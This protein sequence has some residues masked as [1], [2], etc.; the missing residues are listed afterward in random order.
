MTNAISQNLTLSSRETAYLIKLSWLMESK[1]RTATENFL[2]ELLGLVFSGLK[3]T[4]W[5]AISLRK[6][7]YN[8]LK[9]GRIFE[10]KGSSGGS[11]PTWD[12]MAVTLVAAR[13]NG[14]STKNYHLTCDIH[15][16][17]VV[18]QCC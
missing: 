1:I 8:L 10:Y 5:N 4:T 2:F 15:R 11:P 7:T 6:K 13:K 18:T 14:E 12:N 3:T 17:V 16:A 9:Y